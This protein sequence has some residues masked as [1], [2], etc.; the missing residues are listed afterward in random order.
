MTGD[1]AAPPGSVARESPGSVDATAVNVCRA[2]IN[3][4]VRLTLELSSAITTLDYAD[5]VRARGE[6]ERALPCAWALGEALHPGPE[7]ADLLGRLA[8]LRVIVNRQLA[9]APQPSSA[10]VK[11]AEGGDQTVW[12][13]EAKAWI[14]SRLA[15]GSSRPKPRSSRRDTRPERPAALRSDPSHAGDAIPEAAH[16][17]NPPDP[18]PDKAGTDDRVDSPLTLAATDSPNTTSRT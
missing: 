6:L 11:A 7:R 15:R 17:T 5:G 3:E 13:R 10:A 9:I 2:A 12:S 16:A 14:A 8:E 1:E 4:V 18:M